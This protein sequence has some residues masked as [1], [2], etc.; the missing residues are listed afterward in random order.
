MSRRAPP[1]GSWKPFTH[2][3]G[4]QGGGPGVSGS[5]TSVQAPGCHTIER[6]MPGLGLW[7]HPHPPLPLPPSVI[8]QPSVS[9]SPH[10]CFC[11]CALSLPPPLFSLLPLPFPPLLL[12]ERSSPTGRA[13]FPEWTLA[14]SREVLGLSPWSQNSHVQLPALCRGPWSQRYPLFWGA[15]GAPD[16]ELLSSA[17]RGEVSL[18]QYPPPMSFSQPLLNSSLNQSQPLSLNFSLNIPLSVS[19]ALFLFSLSISLS[20]N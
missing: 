20:L 11:V 17:T 3:P 2:T 9:V 10:L 15:G 5:K 14:L 6:V 8:T 18:S 19:L 16:S 13:R 4:G 12:P 1:G 7:K